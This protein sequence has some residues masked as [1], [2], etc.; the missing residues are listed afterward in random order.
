MSRADLRHKGVFLTKL[1]RELPQF[2]ME[3]EAIKT[4][5]EKHCFQQL[6]SL[7]SKER[8]IK[9][10]LTEAAVS[11]KESEPGER[12]EFNLSWML[13]CSRQLKELN[14]NINAM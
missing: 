14:T 3:C 6:C 10:H 11:R 4:T 13:T 12:P 1:Q 8:E 9:T 5:A 2:K 7:Q